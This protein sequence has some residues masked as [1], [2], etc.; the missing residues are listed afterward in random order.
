MI[1]MRWLRIGLAI[2]LLAAG[3]GL[4]H[5]QP[6]DALADIRQ[7]LL[8]ARYSEAEQ[9]AR[10]MLADAEAASSPDSLA[11]AQA[12]DVLVESLWRGGKV[13]AAETNTLAE[14]AVAI[15]EAQLGPQ[16][17]DFGYSL[18]TLGIVVRLRGDYPRAKA[19][20]DRAL[21]I[22]EAALGGV[23]PD[24]ARTLTSAAGLVSEAGDQDGAQALYERALAI[25]EKTVPADEAAVAE[26]LNGLG[27]VLERR[28]DDSGAEQYHQKALAMR[29]KALGPAHP[30]VAASLNNL[31]NVR[32]E[33]G[34][35][36]AARSFHERALTIRETAL[37]PDH[38]DVAG[39]L[40][41]LSVAVRDLG[42]HAAAWWLLERVLG[43]YEK[44]FGPAHPNVAIATHNLATI[45]VDLGE[46]DGGRL[47]DER[48]RRV[49]AGTAE[50]R[51][52][53]EGL[54]SIVGIDPPLTSFRA[55]RALLER[56]QSIKEKA[57]G[58]DHNSVALTLTT[59]AN[60]HVRLGE[61][62]KGLPLHERA[63]AIREKLFGPAHPLVADTLDRLGELYAEVDDHGAAVEAWERV[64]TILEKTRGPDHP[65]VGVVRQHL[66]ESLGAMGDVD[67]ALQMALE[68]ERIGRD[69]LRLIG[70]TLPEREA[71]M[72]AAERPVGSDVA[73][74]LLV[75][76]QGMPSASSAIV[77]D[78]I[79]R[80]RAVVLDEMASRHRT[81][82]AASDPDLQRLTQDHASKREQLARLMVRGPEG[83]DEEFRIDLERAR[84]ERDAAERALAERNV[85]FRHD[86][87]QRRLGFDDIKA[88]LPPGSALVGFVRY[89]HQSFATPP[90]PRTGSPEPVARYLAFV[91]RA[92]D[93]GAP[94]VVPVG[95]A[96]EIDDEIARWRKQVMSVAL[97]GGRSTA[98]AETA[99]RQSGSL[100]RARIWDP[101]VPRIQGASRVFI[102]P[103][104]ALHLVNWEALP[105][106]GSGYLIE[107]APLLHYLSAER[108]LVPGD[109]RAAGR[110]LVVVDSPVFNEPPQSVARAKGTPP[111]VAALE[112]VPDAGAFRGTRSGCGDFRSMQFEPLPAS[113]R[114]AET[115]LRIWRQNNDRDPEL[116]LTGRA[117][118]EAA[119]KRRAAGTRVLHLAT[120]GFFLG[121]RCASAI[122]DQRD[123]AVVAGRDAGENPLLLA[124]FALT[125]ANQRHAVGD[126][127]EDGILTA[128]EV[129]AL[130][131]QGVEWAVLSACDTGVGEV[132]A[133]E[134]VFGL[135]RAFQVAGARTVIMSLW[136]VDD[137]DTRR[138]MT[139]LYERR[140]AR[141]LGTMEALRESTL[142]ELRRRRK[143]GLSTHPFYWGGFIAAGEWR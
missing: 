10:G 131:L 110:G 129:A 3:P 69:H 97:A 30:D 121:G 111:T 60:V 113:G 26:N 78:T 83:S 82:G 117:A 20:F 68:A 70:R 23:H 130:D 81:Y 107:Q 13:R 32:S 124:G 86:Q 142:D 37:G 109:D 7:L 134:G 79:V 93:T 29:E 42:D 45:L 47:L 21:A 62:E 16:H 108:D 52:L 84:K 28:G 104:G 127:E 63:L 49:R 137:E 57:L 133:G 128:E 50:A 33:L 103:D 51:G 12:I 123:H 100:L 9:R 46:V 140:F 95:P 4:L 48:R 41:N 114:E 66:A 139:G 92:G 61:P 96:A 120:H 31:G 59:L 102:V 143:A 99:L 141:G 5:P 119:L 22:Q 101:L 71:L 64:L 43:I 35:Y 136:P 67:G 125:G 138:W 112:P 18:A 6:T 106:A 74:T 76:A 1:D 80:S 44:V 85:A 38:P 77:W 14:R 17:K 11:A 132:R 40:N 65:H 15:R 73:L 118:T 54:N 8:A 34:D 19:L 36:A 88:A 90:T 115:I 56:A 55:A 2:L 89:L 122:A 105:A 135:R 39:S 98:R 91:I 116:R 87:L 24:V 75:R 27:V 53:N 58:P 94:G 126:D 72:Y 25:R